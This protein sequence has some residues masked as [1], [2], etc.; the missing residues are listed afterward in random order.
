MR[1]WKRGQ[2]T[3]KQ[4]F[5]RVFLIKLRLKLIEEEKKVI[6]ALMVVRNKIMRSSLHTR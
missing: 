6:F 1:E 4:I 3:C 5:E 2:E